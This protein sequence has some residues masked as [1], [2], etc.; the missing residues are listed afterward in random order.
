MKTKHFQIITVVLFAACGLVAFTLFGAGR[1]ASAATPALEF[2]VDS[3][4]GATTAISQTNS[5]I[6]GIPEDACFT[7]AGSEIAITQGAGLFVNNLKVGVAIS[8]TYRGDLQIFLI[9]PDQTEVKLLGSEP[10]DGSEHLNLWFDPTVSSNRDAVD[11]APFPPYYPNSWRP[12]GDVWDFYQIDPLGTWELKICD[13]DA[14]PS[15]NTINGELFRWTLYLELGPAVTNFERSYKFAPEKVGRYEP[16][17][18]TIHIKNSGALT[19][20]NAVLTDYIP[21]K[22]TYVPNS[23][24]CTSGNCFYHTSTG[25]DY[26]EWLDD[27]FPNTPVTR[28]AVCE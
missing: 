16:I 5:T 25:G 9:A 7:G 11:H 8:H 20:T 26:I 21:D 3:P 1:L 13:A 2:D 24:S 14:T 19:A 4:L 18:Y 28:G 17:T 27:V 15:H 10:L 22:T 6:M 23:L 12:E